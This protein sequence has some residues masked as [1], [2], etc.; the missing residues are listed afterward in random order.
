MLRKEPTDRST[1]ASIATDPWLTSHGVHP[2][3][4]PV[5]AREMLTA[6]RSEIH[7][8]IDIRS[9]ALDLA[10]GPSLRSSETATLTSARTSARASV[11]SISTRATERS[12][13]G[14]LTAADR[15]RS[16]TW[17]RSHTQQFSFPIRPR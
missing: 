16:E 6:T 11:V 3:S 1:L 4:L 5:A 9:P 14:T 15:A 13:G 2:L 8:A 12:Q 7:R 17:A 10:G